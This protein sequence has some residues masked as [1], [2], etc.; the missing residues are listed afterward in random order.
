M[1]AVS[2]TDPAVFIQAVQRQ[3]AEQRAALPELGFTL[4][5]RADARPPARQRVTES[6]RAHARIGRFQR[7][8]G[9]HGDVAAALP[10]LS[11]AE[12]PPG[13]G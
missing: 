3:W 8:A 9:C 5:H 1:I 4:N 7:S 11:G 12:V 13:V 10:P 6:S 2:V